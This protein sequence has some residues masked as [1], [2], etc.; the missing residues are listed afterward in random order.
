MATAKSLGILKRCAVPAEAGGLLEPVGSTPPLYRFVRFANGFAVTWLVNWSLVAGPV[1]TVAVFLPAESPA[2]TGASLPGRRSSFNAIMKLGSK[3]LGESA[4]NVQ[5][6]YCTGAMSGS[7]ASR[8]KPTDCDSQPQ[9]RLVPKRGRGQS[10]RTRKRE[11]NCPS[12]A[13]PQSRNHTRS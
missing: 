5:C 10:P 7:S 2:A 11:R 9:P 3:S 12:P 6:R 1:S 13:G 8:W 4:R